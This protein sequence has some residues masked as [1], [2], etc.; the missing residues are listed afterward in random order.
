LHAHVF[1]GGSKSGLNADQEAGIATG[2]TTV[3]DAGSAG[4]DDWATF[5]SNVMEQATTRVLA[6]LNISTGRPEGPRHGEWRNFSQGR[7][8]RL[9][10]EEAAAGYCLGI[11]VL[12]S[13]THCGNMGITPVKLARQAA[14]LSGTGLMVHIGNAPPLIDEVLDL[15]EAG[16]IVTHC[17]HGKYGGL[18]GRDK[19]PL[20]ATKAAVERGV[21]FDM[22]HGSASF[23]FDTARHALD[24]GLPLHAIST[25][26]HRG[27]SNGPV[28]DQ[29]TTMAKCLHLGF[30]LPEVIR[31]STTS[32][33][34]LMGRS[35]TLGSL[36]VGG[37]AD[38]T[39]FRIV[40]GEFTFTDS[41]RQTEQATRQLQVLYTVR[42]GSVVKTPAH[43][44]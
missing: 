39:V 36:A 13:Q 3:V 40:E 32:P 29:G 30:S 12:A 14:R 2:V 25:D 15:L 22:G 38:L 11:K 24:A 10:E 6:F 28:F 31:L 23:A 20:P 34:A 17:W 8:I 33:A 5:R 43:E 27:C 44:K 4:A 37:A 18:L 26:L 21:K 35:G 16:D 7:T 19:K 1:A 9:A 42:D 41:E